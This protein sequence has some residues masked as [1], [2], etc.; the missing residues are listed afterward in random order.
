MKE[1]YHLRF[2]STEQLLSLGKSAYMHVDSKRSVN[3]LTSMNQ[4]GQLQP[5]NRAILELAEYLGLRLLDTRLNELDM[6]FSEGD[7]KVAEQVSDDLQLASDVVVDEDK[8]VVI[9]FAHRLSL[10]YYK[11]SKGFCSISLKS[12][13]SDGKH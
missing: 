10:K 8:R 2:I 4:Q 3:F 12:S 1:M 9:A 6:Q 11:F 5:I 13:V 7:V